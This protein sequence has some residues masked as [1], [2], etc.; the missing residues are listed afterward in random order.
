MQQR[1]LL[2]GLDRSLFTK[3]EPLLSRSL[4]AVDRVSRGESGA[5]LAARVA[6]DLVIVRYPLPDMELVTFLGTVRKP[7]SASG[8]GQLLMLAD[9]KDIDELRRHVPSD[10]GRVLSIEEP[11][12]LLE[13]TASRLLGVVARVEARL[14]IRLEVHIEEGRE[15]VM[16]QSE[17]LS[18]AGILLKTDR[19]YP[20][21]TRVTFDMLLPGEDREP[22]PVAGE[23][24]RHAVP[25]VEG[26]RG[27]GVAYTNL[28]GEGMERLKAF[29]N[30]R[31]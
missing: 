16:C 1:I 4:F 19:V 20:L 3:L 15:L 27:I 29:L 21:G 25:E 6:F 22:I 12:K 17:N 14:L 24:A 31:R 7:G 26:V 10:P 13:E 9:P 28:R 30:Q 5:A 11:W 2:V 23:V 18:A 8:R